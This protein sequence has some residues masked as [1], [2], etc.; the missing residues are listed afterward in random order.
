[1]AEKPTYE[2]LE[3]R[4]AE[5]ERDI[6]RLRT[7]EET[8]RNSEAKYRLLVESLDRDY[9]I[10]SHDPEGKF[11][12]LSPS[13]FNVLGYT[14]EEFMG[15]YSEYM[16]D[17]P[18]NE[19]AWEYTAAALRGEKQPPFEAEYWHKN[20]TR[21]QIRATEV[22][23]TDDQGR[24]IAI[25]GIVQ[26]I[27]ELKK[28]EAEREDLIGRLHRALCKSKAQGTLL[29]MC[30]ECEKVKDEDGEWQ[31]IAV[32]VMEHTDLGFTHGYCPDCY[33]K[34]MVNMP[35]ADE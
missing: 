12:Y 1:M 25:E 8:L 11:T 22:P 20:G 26:D 5:Y 14:Q 16:T 7:V 6:P 30:A 19:R 3:Q 17:N 9:I 33:E 13:I 28:A 10:Y 27:T 34:L 29:S 24:V 32:Y 2:E 18:L 35:P 21:R 23:V 15:H 4:V 31:H